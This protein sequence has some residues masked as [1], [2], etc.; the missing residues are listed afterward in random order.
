MQN[1]AI[2]YV[3]TKWRTGIE[4]GSTIHLPHGVY[5]Y[6]WRTDWL[7]RGH[8]REQVLWRDGNDT[9]VLETEGS[10][11]SEA[12]ETWDVDAKELLELC[13][14]DRP[15]G[16]QDVFLDWWKGLNTALFN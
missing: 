5:D 3:V 6:N 10:R 9:E 15:L 4:V 7:S 8:T 13:H 14:P 16:S 1:A 11:L 2:A 12:M